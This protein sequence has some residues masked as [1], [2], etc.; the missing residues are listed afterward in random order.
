M[1]FRDPSC[2]ASCF[3]LTVAHCLAGLERAA[4]LGL[5]DVSGGV[6]RFDVDEYEHYEQVRAQEA[7]FVLQCTVLYEMMRDGVAARCSGC[8]CSSRGHGH[9]PSTR[10]HKQILNT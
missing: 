10:R 1:P 4:R 3:D 7:G 9:I 8:C 6:W 5:L 2:G